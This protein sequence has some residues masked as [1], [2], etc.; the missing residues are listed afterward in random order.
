[1]WITHIH[2]NIKNNHIRAAQ[3]ELNKLKTFLNHRLIPEL[4]EFDMEV[5]RKGID[6]ILEKY[7][8]LVTIAENE[9]TIR[10]EIKTWKNM[11]IK[12]S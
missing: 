3:K 7:P 6:G 5:E 2:G 4:N 9:Q 12:E 8:R 10:K 1:M 11:E